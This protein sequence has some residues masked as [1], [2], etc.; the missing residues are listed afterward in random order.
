MGNLRRFKN[1]LFLLDLDRHMSRN[2]IGQSTR[3][4]NP[5]QGIQD[6]GRNALIELD[7]LIEGIDHRSDQN[8]HFLI[9]DARLIQQRFDS[10]DQ[11]GLRIGEMTHS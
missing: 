1:G 11:K 5:R 7:V 8:V 6:L 9:I 2:G 10:G 4:F 3:I